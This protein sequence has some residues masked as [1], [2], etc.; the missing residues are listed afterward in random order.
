MGLYARNPLVMAPG[1]GVN[2]FF[3]YNMVLHIG[4]SFEQA[5]GAVFWSGVLFLVLSI[6]KIRETLFQKIPMYIKCSISAGIGLMIAFAGFQQGGLIISSKETLVQMAPL[7]VKSIIFTLALFLT[8]ILVIKKI[9]GSFC[10]VILFTTLF[11]V[12]L[13]R[14]FSVPLIAEYKG[15]FS[16]PDF[17]LIGRID[18]LGSLQWSILPSIF[19]LAF[20]D[21]V[22][23]FG[24]LM[25]VLGRFDL[26]EESEKEEKKPRRLKQ[27]LMADALGTIYSSVFGSSSATVYVE[28]MAGLQEGG[29]TGLCAVVTALLFL[30]FLFLSPLLSMIPDVAVA[31]ILVMVGV[32]MMEPVRYIH[33]KSWG[34]AIPAFLTLSL[35]PLTFSIT[36]GIIWGLGSSLVIG[37]CRKILK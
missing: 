4:M 3:T 18:F 16:W 20:V 9:K 26:T 13:G 30:P 15:F 19:S 2:A 34:Q 32:L 28:S 11:A 36:H 33:W 10:F 5:L 29:R 35:I 37:F 21:L 12:L 6:L 24:T 1:L 25:S 14:W 22:E 23:S 8:V 17:S 27:S 31:P 7:S